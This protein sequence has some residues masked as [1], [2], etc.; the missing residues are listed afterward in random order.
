M[1]KSFGTSI[2]FFFIYC[3]WCKSSCLIYIPH[4]EL[5]AISCVLNVDSHSTLWWLFLSC[6]LF[7]FKRWN[8]IP[9]GVSVISHYKLFWKSH[10]HH[11]WVL[12][13]NGRLIGQSNLLVDQKRG[14]GP[15]NWAKRLHPNVDSTPFP[16]PT[17]KQW[18][19]QQKLMGF[20]KCDKC[21][22]KHNRNCISLWYINEHH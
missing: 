15:E 19:F 20:T 21:Q 6:D 8:I 4:C 17:N 3:I 13:S 2:L 22:I 16:F 1:N 12:T 18:V 5:S 10:L 11:K 9:P 14:L 7:A